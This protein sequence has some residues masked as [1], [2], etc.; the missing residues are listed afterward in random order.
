MSPTADPTN[1]KCEALLQNLSQDDWQH[2]VHHASRRLLILRKQRSL[3]QDV[4]QDAIRCILIGLESAERGR[5]PKVHQVAN[6]SAFMD[7]LMSAIN[8]KASAISPPEL[9]FP[10]SLA[11]EVEAPP[12]NGAEAQDLRAFL[13][14]K[15]RE[16]AS[17]R[18]QPTINAWEAVYSETD[19]VPHVPSRRHAWEVRQLAKKVLKSHRNS[20]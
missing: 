14:P 5:H 15:L 4:V 17:G 11:E 7:Y 19:Q 1:Q 8:S 16:L 20:V 6:K 3:A 13:F 10:I 12:T 18:L 2:L 9:A